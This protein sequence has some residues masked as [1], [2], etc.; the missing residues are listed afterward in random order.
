MLSYPDHFAG[1]PATPP[2][3]GAR[4][5]LLGGSFNPAH[6]GHR[7]ISLAALDHPGLDQ[8][9]WL[10]TPGNPLKDPAS[11]ARYADR[12]SQAVGVADHP[13]IAVS[14]YEDQH[15]FQYT[16]DTLTGLKQTH[17]AFH[18]IWLMGADSLAGF[19]HWR[20]WQLISQLMPIAVFNRPGFEDAATTST[21]ARALAPF[22]I[23]ETETDQLWR[24]TAP[25]WVFIAGTDNP[26]SSTQIRNRQSSDPENISAHTTIDAQKDKTPMTEPTP[27][28]RTDIDNLVAFVDYHPVS[29]DFRQDVIDGLSRDQ[30]L[31]SPKYFYDKRGSE[32]FSRITAT[33]DYYATRTELAL[34]QHNLPAITQAIGP[35][36]AIFEYGSG[37]SE[38]IKLLIDHL[39]EMRA[40]VAMDI[41]REYLIS[42]AQTI[43]RAYPQVHVSAI[44][45]DFN[46]PMT[47]PEDF[48][49]EVDMWTA[50]FPG[51]TIGNFPPG[52]ATDFLTRASET[53]GRPA[54]F[55]LGF[56]LIK[57]VSVLERAYNDSEGVTAAF[58]LNLLVRMQRE[59]GAGVQLAD[60]SHRAIYNETEHRIEMHLVA[61]KATSITIDEQEFSFDAGETLL[62]E[63]S[64]KYT[65]AIMNDMLTRTPWQMVECWTDQKGWFA[66]C[67]LRNHSIS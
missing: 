33:E 61:E 41:S 57:D 7:E 48:H 16:V 25:R 19:H 53:L 3:A 13:S 44:C 1:R 12:V 22:R 35:G 2:Q 63:Y 38:K 32:L 43:A 31:I 65:R 40:Y 4:I 18:F 62:T 10:V 51:S 24:N 49:P 45:A 42:S 29:D 9:W 59:L 27:T 46:T 47:L 5:G 66:V 23:A 39:D 11:Y 64:Y 67:L 37:A 56:D 14:I 54:Q 15:G 55:L 50:Y 52:S 60:F 17:P 21:A 20:D 6:A 30:K 34:M 8:V 58:N 26:L 28:V 36:A